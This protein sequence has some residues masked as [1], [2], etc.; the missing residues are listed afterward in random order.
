[1][2]PQMLLAMLLCAG[3]ALTLPFATSVT[4]NE[5]APSGIHGHVRDINKTAI[6]GVHVKAMRA[7]SNVVITTDTNAD[8]EFALPHLSSGIYDVTFF[9]DGF[10]YMLYPHVRVT[11]NQPVTL[12][13]TLNRTN[14][15][16]PLKPSN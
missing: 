7:K 14:G 3:I 9:K 8:G 5:P 6:A 13:I 15:T 4:A 2:N 1:M 12:D 16:P 10:E 11:K